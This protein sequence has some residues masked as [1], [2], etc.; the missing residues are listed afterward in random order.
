MGQPELTRYPTL[1]K[2]SFQVEGLEISSVANTP[3]R[4][5]LGRHITDG[6]I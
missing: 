3:Q 6:G 1:T 5:P 4:H 2:A